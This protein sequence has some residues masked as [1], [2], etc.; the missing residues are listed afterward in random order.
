MT[1]ARALVGLLVCVSAAGVAAQGVF[2]SG[3]DA[4][5]VDVSVM[6][7]NVPVTGLAAED[8]IV[9]DN[10][11]AQQVALVESGS[12]PLEITLVLDTSASVSGP[13]L[14]GLVS[15][16]QGLLRRLQ[17]G[18]KVALVTFSH[19]VQLRADMGTPARQ[20]GAAMASLVG[21]GATAM[22]DAAFLA[23]DG[24]THGNGARS[25]VLLFSD[26]RD[27]VSWLSREQTIETARTSN[28]V[29]HI[30]HFGRDPFLGELAGITGGRTWSA[31]KDKQLEEL[32]T[33]VLDEM[34][35]RYVLRYTPVGPRTTGW[36]KIEVKLKGKRGEVT[37][38]P[39][40]F[41]G[42]TR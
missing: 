38:R 23:L 29:I 3:V 2:R 33:R 36:H 13:R 4:V 12:L 9:S 26:G 1:S 11:A 5:A 24:V 39:G 42:E 31:S 35:A 10:G 37:A 25:L 8:F 32:F 7:G 15:A 30:V 27:T 18:D 41:V 14:D 21:N 6:R 16:G 19:H 17:P 40:Y 28:A 20:V 22:R 34:R